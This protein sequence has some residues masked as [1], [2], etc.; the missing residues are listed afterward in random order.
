MVFYFA[1]VGPPGRPEGPLQVSDVFKDRAL[2]SW[3]PPKDDGGD[4]IT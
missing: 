2:V 4:E 3:K 1:P